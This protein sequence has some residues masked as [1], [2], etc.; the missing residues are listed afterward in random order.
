M[1][2]TIRKQMPSFKPTGLHLKCED[3][4]ESNPIGPLYYTNGDRFEPVYVD[5]SAPNATIEGKFF[6]AWLSLREARKIAKT[7]NLPLEIF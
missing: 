3:G 4:T 2:D 7:E 1:R 6:S 5:T